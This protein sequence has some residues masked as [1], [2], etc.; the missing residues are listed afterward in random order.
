MG[1]DG[2]FVKESGKWGWGMSGKHLLMA[3][4][5]ASFSKIRCVKDI[6]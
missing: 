3:S 5:T 1:G 2:T 6:Q 4:K